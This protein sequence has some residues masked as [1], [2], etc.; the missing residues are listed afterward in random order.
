MAAAGSSASSSRAPLPAAIEALA[1]QPLGQLAVLLDFDGVLSPIVEDPAAARPDPQSKAA[2]ATLAPS[3][4]LAACITGRAALQARDLLGLPEFTYSG[5]HGAELLLPGAEVPIVPEAFAADAQRVAALIA[6]AEA[7]PDGL[8]DLAVEHKGPIVALHWRR[9]EDPARAE[10]RA[11]ELGAR[12]EAA[13]LRAGAGRA[14]LE[15]RPGLKVTKGDGLRALLSGAPDAKTVLVAGDDVTDLDA[16]AAAAEL[17]AE[18]RL[19]AAVRIAVSGPDA[20][21]EVAAAA[22]VVLA[23]PAELGALLSALA[24]RA[25]AGG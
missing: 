25:P 17:R 12:A 11:R 15:L 2:L 13:G 3:L 10:A 20:P 1:A 18:G 24:S 5:L 23:D 6:E 16:F 7:E 19:T 9:S 14:V 22:D 4:A 21:P 8:A